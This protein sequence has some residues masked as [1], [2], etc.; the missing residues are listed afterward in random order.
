MSAVE[1]SYRF[2]IFPWLAEQ[3]RL[4]KV[5]TLLILGDLTDAKDNHSAE[6]VNKIVA[7]FRMLSELGIIIKILAGNHDW[8]REGHQFFKF[9]DVIP[10]VQFI[11]TPTEDDEFT[12]PL[13]FFLPYSKNPAKDW[14]GMDFSHY[15]YLFMHQTVK[16][17]RSS[18]GQAMDGEP[19]PPLNAVKVYSGDIHVPQIIGGVDYVGSPYHVHMGDAFKPRCVLLERDGNPVDLYFKTLSRMTV[20]IRDLKE[21]GQLKIRPGDQIKVRFELSEADKHDW[22]R[23]KRLAKEVLKE[24][25]AD[26]YGIELL[27]QKTSRRVLLDGKP[28][29]AEAPGTSVLRFVEKEELGGEA[30]DIA[31]EILES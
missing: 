30:L 31:M 12:G 7:V 19:L 27:V 24:K 20:Q 10:G 18:N 6:L 11:S 8:L 15:D 22:S 9:L 29:Q 28:R 13:S 1:C 21:L 25:G 3:C 23:I 5:K 26:I 16:G 14:A 4:E 17:A 2:E